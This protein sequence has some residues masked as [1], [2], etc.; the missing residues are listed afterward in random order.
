MAAKVDG[1]A[2]A[3][4]RRDLTR[5]RATY[6]SWLPPQP[7]RNS[8][9]GICVAGVTSV[10]AIRCSP[11]ATSITSSR[12]DIRLYRRVLGERTDLRVHAAK[13]DRRALVS[14]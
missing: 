5:A 11:T 1:E 14:R 4:E 6:C 7:C 13:M 10:A 12:V 9:E 2:D 3:A 8:T